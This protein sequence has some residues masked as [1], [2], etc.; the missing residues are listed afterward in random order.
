M[1]TLTEGAPAPDFE[2]SDQDGTP[3][4]LSMLLKDG[5]V[6]LFFY[7]AADTPGCTREAC[8]FRNLDAEFTAVGAQRVG[9][10]RDSV[11][12][13]K[14]FAQKHRLGYRLLADEAGEVAAAYGVRR[15]LLGVLA[16]V[17][18]VTFVIGADQVVLKV[19]GSELNMDVHADEA[20]ATL[21]H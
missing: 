1:K 7:P 20:L 18:R 8:H 19:I 4:R 10:S 13:L 17:K 11:A 16:P 5:P 9:I 15:G 3:T 14:T 12:K 21:K 6:V 2:L